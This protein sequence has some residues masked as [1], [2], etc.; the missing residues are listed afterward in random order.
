MNRHVSASL[1]MTGSEKN[2][3][4]RGLRLL[5]IFFAF[6]ACM[7]GLTIFLLFFPGTALDRL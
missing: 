1:N 6:G 5:A 7:C 3:T 2:R 4:P